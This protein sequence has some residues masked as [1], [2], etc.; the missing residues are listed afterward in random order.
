MDQ[1]KQRM[2]MMTFVILWFSYCALMWMFQSRN[3]ENR[4][5]KIPEGVSKLVCDDNPYSNS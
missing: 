4:V 2:L 5:S 1:N 3:A